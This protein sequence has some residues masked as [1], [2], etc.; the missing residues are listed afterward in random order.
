MQS[1]KASIVSGN[2]K[3]RGSG[4]KQAG[5]GFFTGDTEGKG[6]PGWDLGTSETGRHL[7]GTA[8]SGKG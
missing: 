3:R 4:D 2:C 8:G 5:T 7:K 1:V 6:E